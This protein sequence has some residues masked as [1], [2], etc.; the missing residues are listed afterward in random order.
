M[1]SGYIC[2]TLGAPALVPL[3]A[4]TGDRCREGSGVR[5]SE[6]STVNWYGMYRCA[7]VVQDRW[8]GGREQKASWLSPLS[9]L[10]VP[11]LKSSLSLAMLPK[12]ALSC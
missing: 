7:S 6:L 12:G 5:H 9:C 11:V 8:V 4:E 10:R 2:P 1:L 3:K